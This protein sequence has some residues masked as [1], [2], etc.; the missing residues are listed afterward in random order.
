MLGSYMGPIYV[1]L[2][3]TAT[4]TSGPW[5]HDARIAAI[6]MANGVRTLWSADRDFGRFLIKVRNPAVGSASGGE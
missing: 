5:V 6:C 4:S 2:S 1:G 3:M